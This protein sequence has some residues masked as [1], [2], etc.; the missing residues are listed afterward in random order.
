MS[1]VGTG[2]VMKVVDWWGKVGRWVEGRST[3]SNTGSFHSLT[4]RRCTAGG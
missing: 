1:W 2:E 3:L 4:K